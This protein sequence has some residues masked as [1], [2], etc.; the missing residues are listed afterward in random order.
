MTISRRPRVL[1]AVLCALSAGA[2]L[3]SAQ[4]VL[5]RNAPP[6]VTVEVVLGGDTLAAKKAGPDGLAAIPFVLPLVAGKRQLDANVYADSCQGIRRVVSGERGRLP[7]PAG[8][9][10]R[11]DINSTTGCASG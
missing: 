7:P 10:K 4:T 1:A 5:A 8:E 2:R 3:A 11:R 6:D 9:G